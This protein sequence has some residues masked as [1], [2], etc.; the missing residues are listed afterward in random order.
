M[1]RPRLS[2]IIPAFNEKEGIR[3]TLEEL[4]AIVSDSFEIIVV[5]DGS[6]DETAKIAEQYATKVIRHPLNKGKGAAMRTGYLSAAGD[7]II[8]LDADGTYPAKYI[9]E[10]AKALD[11]VD[12]VFTRRTNKNHIPLLNR[13]GNWLITKLIRNLSGFTGH[14]P[15]SGLYGMRRN[16][17]D[18]IGLESSTFAIETEIV[19]KVSRMRFKATEIPITYRPRLGFSKLRP[20]KD[21]LRIFR[22]LIDLLFIFR[23]FL[24]FILPGTAI[25][26]LGLALT[27]ILAIKNSIS[28]N[29]VRLGIHTFLTGVALLLLGGNIAVYG[30]IIDLYAVRHRFKKPSRVTRFLTRLSLYKNLRNLSLLTLTMSA[31][32]LV[33]QF[34]LWTGSGFGPFTATRT[35]MLSLTGLLLGLQGLFTSIIGRIFAKECLEVNLIDRALD[36]LG[37]VDS[38]YA[39]C[40]GK[41]VSTSR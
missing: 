9:P 32:A 39:L 40:E 24:T 10:I 16:V 31:P 28:L 38:Q 33:Y 19:V 30:G 18:S 27:S 6:N 13:F 5:D 7:Y 22:V 1:P 29:G 23:P 25:F 41:K 21:G 34:Y 8:F 35:W 3:F 12:I 11:K 26:L 15:L 4:K 17:L 37:S 36:N 14:D 20:F 2:I